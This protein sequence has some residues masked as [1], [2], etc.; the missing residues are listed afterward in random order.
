[1]AIEMKWAVATIVAAGVVLSGC[2]GSSSSKMRS[3]IVAQVNNENVTVL[4]LNQALESAGVGA[5]TPETVKAAIDS[6]VD[7]E[8]LIQQA[9]KHQMDRD[10]SVVQAMDQA[11]RRVLAQAYAQ[12]MLYP[13]SPI[14]LA[15][16]E[17]YYRSHQA[18]FEHRRLYRLTAF[19][20]PTSDMTERLSD[21]LSGTHSVD[22]VRNVLEHHEIKFETQ[23]INSAAEDLP[24]DKL[25]EFAKAQV[26]DLLILGHQDGKTSLLS[27]VSVEEHPLS[28]EHAKPIVER[29]LTTIRNKEATAA[30]LKRVRETAKISVSA[31]Y[32]QATPGTAA[33]LNSTSPADPML[34]IASNRPDSRPGLN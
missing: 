28:F 32:T 10:P 1:M 5:A 2:G 21:D 17:Q 26:G 6:L 24:L 16:E 27:V 12:R 30:Y 18:L 20:L 15:D 7:E 23:Q 13:K 33:T 4:Q 19:T 8:L 29:Y 9:V 34:S 14:T 31:R 3:Q 11:R 25:D 22:D